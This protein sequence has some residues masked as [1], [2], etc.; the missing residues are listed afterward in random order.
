MWHGFSNHRTN[1]SR[2]LSP[3]V[4]RIFPSRRDE[5]SALPNRT[6]P[7]QLV[8]QDQEEQLGCVS[9]QSMSRHLQPVQRNSVRRQIFYARTNCPVHSRSVPRQIF[10]ENSTRV[11]DQPH[12]S[13]GSSA[14]VTGQCRTKTND[15]T[16]ERSG[17]RNRR[18]VP[19]RRGKKE[20]GTLIRK[21]HLAVEPTNGVD[22]VHT[23][24]IGHQ[25]AP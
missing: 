2:S 8:S 1:G 4:G 14:P 19:E 5:M 17:S 24:M 9:V 15:R 20:N 18:N 12:N 23:R 7:G 13:Y 16:L 10:G 25:F 11:E 22:A 21:I 6:R 3:M